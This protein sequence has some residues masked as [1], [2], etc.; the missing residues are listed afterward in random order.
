[1]NSK[2][3]IINTDDNEYEALKACQD[4]Y[5][6]DNDT[7]SDL[8]S[9]PIE[10]IV[11]MWCEGG[12]PWMHGVIK[13]VIYSYCRGRAYIIRM[14]EMGKLI[15]WNTRHICSTPL[16]KEQLSLGTDKEKNYMIRVI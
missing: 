7:H 16:T 5:E 9:F 14:I 8:L 13:E 11:T 12:R 1:M 2:P 6:K 10:C 15:M 4:K 3:M